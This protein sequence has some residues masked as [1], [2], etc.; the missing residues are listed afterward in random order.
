MHLRIRTR[1][2]EM[3]FWT[4]GRKPPGRLKCSHRARSVTHLEQTAAQHVVPLGRVGHDR[5]RS[6]RELQSLTGI[7]QHETDGS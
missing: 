2:I 6:L 4:A 3:D 5:D 7:V 1:E